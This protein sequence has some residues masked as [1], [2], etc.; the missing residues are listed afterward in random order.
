LE[1][2]I[3]TLLYLIMALRDLPPPPGSLLQQDQKARVVPVQWT[4][5]FQGQ[6]L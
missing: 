4:V 6:E 1:E 2:K 3:K 5:G